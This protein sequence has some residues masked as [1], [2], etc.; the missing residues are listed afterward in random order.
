MGHYILAS[1]NNPDIAAVD[2]KIQKLNLS[3][4]EVSS[5]IEF[6]NALTDD[7]YDQEIPGN[8]PSGL[9]PGGN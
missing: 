8:V 5:I 6:L 2:P 9:K 3:D 4:A 7:S 1:S